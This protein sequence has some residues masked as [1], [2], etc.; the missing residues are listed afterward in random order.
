MNKQVQHTSASP[1]HYDK[2]AKHYDAFN[3]ARSVQIN[4]LI[5]QVLQENNVKTVLDLTCGT[6]S[7]VFWLAERDFEVIGIDINEKMLAIASEQAKQK[8]MLLRFELGDMRTSHVGQFDAILTIFNSIGHLT[9]ADFALALQNIHTNLNHGGFYIFDI[10]N[11]DYLQYEDNITKL[12]IDWQ[13]KSG[14]ITAREIQYSTI[15]K[16]GVLASYDIY[17]EQKGCEA[18]TISTAFQ[19]LQ[20]Y[21]AQQLKILLEQRGFKVLQQTDIDGSPLIPTV[22][23]RILTVA[24]KQ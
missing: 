19:T 22:S 24:I 4:Q 15:S 18:S 1:A 14:D 7:Q 3:E 13:K 5:E 12:T 2:E 17:H 20:V 8:N 21:S 6:G 16:A 9:K 11:L 10:F 23:E